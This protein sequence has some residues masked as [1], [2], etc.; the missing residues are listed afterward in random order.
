MLI[1]LKNCFDM[2]GS[3]ISSVI[4]DICDISIRL[5]SLD[6]PTYNAALKIFKAQSS[7]SLAQ[8]V[9]SRLSVELSNVHSSSLSHP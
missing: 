8:S 1:K 6:V 7:L 4:S 9:L 3:E 5:A 2:I